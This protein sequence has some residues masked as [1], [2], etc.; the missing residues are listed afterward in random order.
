MTA[1]KA[2][3]EAITADT[4]DEGAIRARAAD[5][6]AVEADAAVLRAK[7]HA[8]VFAVLTPEQQTKA[9]ELRGTMENRM[10][11]GRERIRQHIEQQSEPRSEQAPSLPAT[12]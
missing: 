10:R 7:L 12:V 1:R 5:V 3:D 2:L 8:A 11:G 9:K 4:L 6:G